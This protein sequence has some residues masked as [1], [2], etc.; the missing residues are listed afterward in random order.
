MST[1]AYM[2]GFGSAQLFVTCL[3]SFSRY[4]WHNFFGH[5]EYL[6]YRNKERNFEVGTTEKISRPLHSFSLLLKNSLPDEGI[7]V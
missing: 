2:K 7:P 1:F 3:F 5:E 4:S 6:F